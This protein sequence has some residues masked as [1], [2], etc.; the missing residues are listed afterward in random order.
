MS[1]G[2]DVEVKFGGDTRDLDAASTKASQDMEKV[3][4]SATGL[5]GVFAKVKSGMDSLKGTMREGFARGYNEEMAKAG[6]ETL[7]F[8]EISEKVFSNAEGGMLSMVGSLA[9]VG[10]A[11]GALAAVVGLIHFGAEFGDEAEKLDQM[12]HKLGMAATEVSKWGNLAT[13]A[14]M[15]TD[16][17]AASAQ[18]LE[19]T[20][21][22]AAQGGKAQSAAFKALGIDIKSVKNTSELMMTVADKFAAMDDGPKKTA[23][24]MQLMG[25]AGANMIPILNQGS[26]AIEEQ[27]AMADE[28]GANASEDFMKAGLAVDDAMDQMS[29]GTKGLKDMLFEELAPA[30]VAVVTFLNDLVKEMVASYRSGGLVAQILGVMAIAFKTIITVIDSVCTG[31]R[32]LYSIAVGV[33]QGILGTIYSVGAALAKLLS[34][35]FSGISKAWSDGMAG[36][37][38]AVATSFNEAGAAG[39]RYRNRMRTLWGKDAL[40]GV[41]KPGGEG[42][43]FGDLSAGAPGAKGKK[44]K[45]DNSAHKAAEAQ[46]KNELEDLSY[47]QDEA[48]RQEDYAKMMELEGQKLAKLKAFYGEN[49]R[50]YIAEARKRLSM[51][52]TIQQDIVK[53][54]ETRINNAE[55]LEES[56]T[57]SADNLRNIAL[58]AEKQHF[59]A[60]DQLGMVNN[61]QR[62]AAAQQ[63]AQQD[64]TLQQNHENNIFNLKAQALRDQ[65]ALDNLLAP[66]RRRI[67]AELE[68]LE[69]D[70]QGR[71]SEI[72]ANAAVQTQVIQDRAAQQTLQ[73]WTGILAPVGNAMNGFLTS[74]ATRSQSFH[75]ALLQM[76]DALV[77]AL[78]QQGVQMVMKWAA[79]E[80]AKTGATATSVATRTGLEATG[81]ATSTAISAGSALK[82]IA[83]KAAVA[84]AGAYAAIASIP[85]VGPFLAP[86]AAAAALFG[87]MK[88]AQSIFSAEGGWGNV[89]GDGMQTELH[90]NEMV[91]PAKF[92]N[93]LRDMLLSPRGSDLASNTA[94]AGQSART[95]ISNSSGDVNFHYKPQHTNNNARMDD[96]LRSDASALRKWFQNEV[97]NNSLKVPGL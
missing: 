88:L 2:N 18:K 60:L 71:L 1:G 3:G 7:S 46:L 20:T 74:M 97:R 23:L 80:L 69:V 91:L 61:Q 48:K 37:G 5:Q 8:G 28:Y 84:A 22:M 14:G 45:T 39:E 70:H 94:A 6:H 59:D 11:A 10:I 63:F 93:P 4:K 21:Y 77:S 35:D 41:G 72:R 68:Q 67:Q 86:A 90:K 32:Q 62:I 43:D 38:R 54:N 15:S 55:K 24:A 73:R 85:V 26:K 29:L 56:R 9:K 92:A 82:Q 13:T 57:N 58:Q 51:E 64:E 78:V 30:I 95:D 65:L 36:T 19:R 47:Q 96:L 53:L 31:F 66:E 16:A 25:R 40:G 44:P 17:F 50:E 81:A 52:Q 83:H 76:G 12:A 75:A 79:M 89:P 34:G 49:S 42:K 27:M 87:V 33:L